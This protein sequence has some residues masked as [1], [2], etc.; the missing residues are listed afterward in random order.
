M[1]LYSLFIETTFDKEKICIY[2]KRI[3]KYGKILVIG[4]TNNG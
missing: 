3:A 2:L 1:L 4:G